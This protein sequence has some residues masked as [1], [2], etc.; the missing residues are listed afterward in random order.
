ML[1]QSGKRFVMLSVI[2]VALLFAL[3]LTPRDWKE[4]MDYSKA[5]DSSAE[6]RLNSWEYS[7]N[8]ALHYPMMG[9]GFD[10]FTS[11]LYAR[12]APNPRLTYGPHNIYFGVLAE[13]GFPGLFLYLSLLFSCFAALYRI[14]IIASVHGDE[15]AVNYSKMLRLSLFGYLVC[16]AFLGRQYFDYFFVLV[17]CVAILKELVF[18]FESLEISQA[19][20]QQQWLE[21]V[22]GQKPL[23][24]G[25]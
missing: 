9:G 20:P 24:D 12:F 11:P 3:F 2:V 14:G 22:P 8:L 18:S 17:A 5:L 6:A 23:I 1:V 15:R 13:H 19:I 4:R 7:W 10:T 16:G 21:P 25:M